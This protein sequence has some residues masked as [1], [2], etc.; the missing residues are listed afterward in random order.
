VRIDVTLCCPQCQH[1]WLA[2]IIDPMAWWAEGTS[3]QIVAKQC[4]CPQCSHQPPMVVV[5]WV[6]EPRQAELFTC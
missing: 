5:V 3:P 6:D 2:A 4:Y 1:Q